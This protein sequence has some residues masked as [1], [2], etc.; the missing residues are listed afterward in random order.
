MSDNK[1]KG[2]EF[3]NIKTGETHYAVLGPQ[4]QAFIN[5][6]DMGINASHGQDFGWRLGKEWVKKV[7]VFRSKEDKM[8]RL[9]EK[10]GGKKPSVSQILYTI[11]GEQMRVFNQHAEEN[12]NP[13][14]EEYLQSI[15]SKVTSNK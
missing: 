10:N 3:F 2:I 1:P 8:E 14:E 4:I 15:S 7:R 12:E 13:F 5:S 9:T 6:S 11:Y